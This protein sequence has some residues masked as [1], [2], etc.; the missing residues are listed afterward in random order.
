MRTKS[1][2]F[3]SLREVH[4]WKFNIQ[5]LVPAVET[6]TA[7]LSDKERARVNRFLFP[8]R[9]ITAIC[10]RG[11]LRWILACYLDQ[12]PPAVHIET[13]PG[14]KPYLPDTGLQ[15]NLSH[16]GHYLFCAV[17][18]KN[19]LGIDI[20]EIY[21]ISGL[22]EISRSHFQPEQVKQILNLKEQKQLESFFQNWVNHEAQIKAEGDG[23][24]IHPERQAYQIQPI[25][26]I[27]SI[28][29][30]WHTFELQAPEG[31]K[32]ALVTLGEKTEIQNQSLIYPWF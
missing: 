12:S 5:K 6:F 22:E 26:G 19:P 31:Y 32:A 20:Q 1:V 2:S 14:G 30:P 3:R 27:N 16:S 28:Q 17:G 4:L 15:F 8:A 24:R 21:P 11:I 23:F 13:L 25:P 10:S 9:K 18:Q 7:W 29:P